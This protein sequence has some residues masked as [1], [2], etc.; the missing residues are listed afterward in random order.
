MTNKLTRERI[1]WLNYAATGLAAN[2]TEIAMSP[3]DV[4]SL[5]EYCLDAMDSEPVAFWRKAFRADGFCYADGINSKRYHDENPPLPL[6][7]GD[8]WEV[9]PLYRHAQHPVLPDRLRLA[10]S[11]AGIAAPE[12]DEILA[13]THEKCI[14]MLVTW[15]KDLKLFQPAPIVSSDGR[16]QF[17]EWFKFHHGGEYSTCKL[18]RANGGANYRDPHVDLAWIAWRDSRAAMLNSEKLNQPVSDSYKLPVTQ[19]KPVADLYGITSPTGSETT[20]TF[21]AA[22][23][24]DFAKVGWSVQEYVELERYQEAM[25]GNPPVTPDGWREE[26]E[27]LAEVYGSAFVIF[28][29]GEEPVCADP[30]KFWFGFDP[31]APDFREITKASTNCPKCGGRGTYHC[32]QMPGTVEC[33]CALSVVPAT[34]TKEKLTIIL[35]DTSSKAF[36]SGSGRNE[37]FHP[38]TYKCR[39]KEAIERFCIIAS[40]DVEVKWRNANAEVR[41]LNVKR[42]TAG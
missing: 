35:P 40:I 34:N 1:E 9:I 2:G 33:E 18:H 16:D 28:R 11:N 27:K 20:F 4:I 24:S 15:V 31:A 7:D 38:E 41:P 36:W 10:L 25:A 21:D 5:T 3:Q 39:V 22:E 19:I 14:Q 30:T 26:A 6:H 32:P 29:H 13:A 23:A 8:Y 37:V 17:E 42:Y 12:S